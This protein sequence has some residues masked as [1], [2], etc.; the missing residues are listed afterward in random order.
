MCLSDLFPNIE[1]DF[2]IASECIYYFKNNER[3]IV[4]EKLRRGLSANGLFYANMPTYET[5]MYMNYK[6]RQKDEDGMVKVDKTGS[7]SSNLMV[8]LPRNK[9][10]MAEM[11][12]LFHIID[13]MTTDERIY[14]EIPMVEYHILAR[15]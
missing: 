10:E 11:F 13:I 14:S 7:V 8:N 15:K 1:F 5:A 3:R 12:G 2:I 6:D 9:N 4:L